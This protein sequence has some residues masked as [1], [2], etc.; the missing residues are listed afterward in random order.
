MSGYSD[1]HV[2]YYIGEANRV[3]RMGRRNGRRIT[4][5]KT[6]W[7]SSRRFRYML[8]EASRLART[9]WWVGKRNVGTDI[10]ISRRSL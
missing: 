4:K 3:R 9:R 8:L 7:K 10:P 6:S 2:S 1:L 5:D